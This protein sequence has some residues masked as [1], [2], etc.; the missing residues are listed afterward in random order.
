MLAS[1][2]LLTNTDDLSMSR[3][4]SADGGANEGSPDATTPDGASANGPTFI[5]VVGGVTA[6]GISS[7]ALVARVGDDGDLSTWTPAPS[8]PFKR[9]R[10]DIGFGQAGIVVCGGDTPTGVAAACTLGR[11]D[12]HGTILGWSDL[13]SLPIERFRH[14]TIVFGERVFVIGGFRSSTALADVL[15]SVHGATSAF[16]PWTAARSLPE[17]REAAVVAGQ[18]PYIWVVQ[19]ARVAID[20]NTDTGWVSTIGTDGVLGPWRAVPAV[21]TAANSGAGAAAPGH[22]YVS[23]G[24]VAGPYNYVKSAPILPDGMLGAWQPRASMITGR[25]GHAMVYAKG[26]LFAIG[27]ENDTTTAVATV[28]VAKVGADGT[29]S[30]WR[31]AT[32]LPAPRKFVAAV[33]LGGP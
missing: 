18:G 33:T 24:Y 14:G 20:G 21:G 8:L 32:P 16:S 10:A 31:A 28:E 12:A 15:T 1:C 5:A 4:A 2:T 17:G 9:Q 27:G 25:V 13:P 29:L 22:V 11:V 19:G 6:E 26:H 3:P 30:P 23:G 7:D